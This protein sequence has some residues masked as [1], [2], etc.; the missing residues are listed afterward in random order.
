MQIYPQK[1]AGSQQWIHI[2][3]GLLFALSMIEAL[4]PVITDYE[5]DGLHADCAI[6]HY[7]QLCTGHCPLAFEGVVDC[8]GGC[9]SIHIKTEI[10]IVDFVLDRTA[11]DA[12]VLITSQPVGSGGN[13]YQLNVY[14]QNAYKAF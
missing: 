12:H 6:V 11:A 8:R 1:H 14:G 5:K 9:D 2:C 3:R 13:Q 10:T 7:R 4:T